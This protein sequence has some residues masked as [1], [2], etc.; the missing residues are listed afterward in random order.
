MGKYGLIAKRAKAELARRELAR[1]DF[2]SFAKY[3]YPNFIETW[4]HHNYYT[5]LNLFAH[6]HIK[7][8]IVSVPPQHGKSEGS[9]RLLPAYLLGLNP[10]L[11][12][13]LASYAA[14]FAKNKLHKK[15]QKYM[16]SKEYRSLFP[17]SIIPAPGG[18][19][20]LRNSE[21]TEMLNA[22]GSIRAVGRGGGITGT[23]GDIF[24]IDDLYKGHMEANSPVIRQAAIDWYDSEVATRLHNDSQ[25]LIVFT[26]WHEEDLVGYIKENAVVY[27][28]KTWKD[29]EDVPDDDG[30]WVLINFE[31]IKEGKSTELDPR[32]QGDALWPEK[33]SLSKLKK[34]QKRAPAVFGSLYQGDPKPAEGLLYNNFQTYSKRPELTDI[35][36][37]ADTADQGDDYL[38]AV[39]YGI[40]VDRN[41]YILDILYTQ[42]D[43]ELTEPDTAALIVRNNVID[44][45]IE[46][47]NGGRGFGRNVKRILN[48]TYNY[49]CD[50]ELFYNPLNKEAR[51]LTHKTNVNGRVFFPEGW[52]AQFPVFAS[53]VLSFKKLFKAN[54]YD[55]APDTL[56]GCVEK[57]GILEHG[58]GIEFIGHNIYGGV[59]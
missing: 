10:D 24:L 26:R 41:I 51:I 12:I 43:M 9:S 47:N 13:T 19:E 15:V 16:D 31:A 32:K 59:K 34:I 4:F 29:L 58:S 3:I 44:G 40:G 55:D 28:V 33:H 54:R 14:N 56:T 6:G 7:R 17:N 8:L 36:I 20:G 22:D 37:Y 35:K 27:E 39:A 23:T 11:N 30:H 57:S 52:I 25:E 45:H 38:C 46:S 50:I 18:Y 48:D 2:L 49:E 42:D 53:H 1:R 21:E 5:I